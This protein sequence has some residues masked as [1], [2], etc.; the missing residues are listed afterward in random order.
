[1]CAHKRRGDGEVL[2]DLIRTLEEEHGVRPSAMGAR[3]RAELALKW[4]RLDNG[5][6]PRFDGP[7]GCIARPGCGPSTGHHSSSIP[8]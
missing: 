8:S 4:A 1:M 5:R 6:S 7:T 3:E 2:R